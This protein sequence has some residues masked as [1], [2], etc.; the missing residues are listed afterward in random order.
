MIALVAGTTAELIKIAPVQRALSVLGADVSI[1]STG[2]HVAEVAQT[3]KDLALPEPEQWLLRE[4]SVKHIARPGQVPGWLL[5][6]CRSVR[7]RRAILRREL[8]RDGFPGLVIVH[9]DTFT[10]VVGAMVG[11]ILGARVAHLEAGMRSGNALSPFPE[12]FNRRLV[13]RLADIHFAPTSR[14]TDNLRHARG[15]VIETGSNTVVDSLR[16]ALSRSQRFND[17]PD[18]FGLVTLHR[19]EL[20]RQGR[21]FAEV[22]H[23]LHAHRLTTPL[24][25]LVGQRERERIRELSLDG[26]FDERFRLVDKCAYVQFVGLLD[27]ASFVVTDSGGLQQECAAMG[28]PCAV[29]RQR[30][31]S[32]DGI[33]QNVVLTE[34]RREQLEAFLSSWPAY[35]VDPVL[36]SHHPSDYVVHVLASLGYVNSGPQV[37]P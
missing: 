24:V 21:R 16:Y 5:Q 31:E 32:S 23:I 15:V 35:R 7:S 3:L 20:L 28:I 12:E 29:Y 26:L 6:I 25:M 11:R 10:T 36:N 18:R 4:A 19:F 30:T 22:L 1:W 14:E 34:Q 13:T 37:R 8:G 9:G 17:L 2:Q 33:G 27:Q